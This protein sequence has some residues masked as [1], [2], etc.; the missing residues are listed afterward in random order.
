MMNS[1]SLKHELNQTF[2]SDHCNFYNIMNKAN[3][4]AAA[5]ASA[6]VHS[7]IQTNSNPGSSYCD[8]LIDRPIKASTIEYWDINWINVPNY[9]FKLILPNLIFISRPC[10][11]FKFGLIIGSLKKKKIEILS[12]KY[13]IRERG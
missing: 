10:K 12:W 9:L 3:L 8:W 11:R 4:W 7:Y 1:N 13:F 5:A 6:L 2:D